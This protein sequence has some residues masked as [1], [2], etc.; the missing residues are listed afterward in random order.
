MRN[1][2]LDE[3]QTGIKISRRNINNLRYADDT[4]LMAESEEELKRIS[5]RVKEKSEKTGFKLKIRR[6]WHHSIH[7]HHFIANRR[8]KSGSSDKFYFLGL[9]I[10]ADGDCRHEYKW[11][12]L[13]GRKAMTNLYSVLKFRN[14]TLMTKDHTVKAIIF[15]VHIQMWELD[16]TED[17]VLKNWC[18]Q[19]VVLK[20][21]FESPLESMVIKPVNPKGNELW[22]FIGR[23]DAK[24]ESPILWPPDMKSQLTWKGTDAREDWSQEEKGTTED[25]MVR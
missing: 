16:H 2:G 5:I 8:G 3:S 12:L 4:T 19:I 1:T 22:I 7:S 9:K 18:F 14:I 21:T 24:A 17:W 15:P 23:T 20:K 25:E 13:L 11:H 6:T 10:T